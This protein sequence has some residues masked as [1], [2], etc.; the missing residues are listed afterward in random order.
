MPNSIVEIYL[1]DNYK[2]SINILPK[3]LKKIN[4]GYGFSHND[5]FYQLI[6]KNNI[7]YEQSINYNGIKGLNG[8]CGVSIYIAKIKK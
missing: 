3:K 7:R 4:I 6:K 2:Q 8:P 1:G 5:E